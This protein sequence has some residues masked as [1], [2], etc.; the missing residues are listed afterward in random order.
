MQLDPRN[1]FIGHEAG[2]HNKFGKFNSFIG[3][4]AGHENTNGKLVGIMYMEIEMYFLAA[5]PAGI[6]SMAKIMSSS[7]QQLVPGIL[8]VA[9]IPLW[10]VL[11]ESLI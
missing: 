8:Q 3:Y 10:E 11:Q 6:I 7:E 2:M 1:Y 4:Q 9:I 5:S